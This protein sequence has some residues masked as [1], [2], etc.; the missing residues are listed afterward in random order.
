MQTILYRGTVIT[1]GLSA[2]LG[3]PD[4]EFGD[5]EAAWRTEKEQVK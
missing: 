1:K 4:V 3:L 2:G 5:G